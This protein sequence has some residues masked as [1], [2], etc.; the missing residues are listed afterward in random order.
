MGQLTTVRSSSHAV[1][2][3]KDTWVL[4]VDSV[5]KQ[6]PLRGYV[7]WD[8]S[9]KEI[10]FETPELAQRHDLSEGDRASIAALLQ[11]YNSD[12][13]FVLLTRS[14]SASQIKYSAQVF[15]LDYDSWRYINSEEEI[16]ADEQKKQLESARY[17][18]QVKRQ[19]RAKKRKR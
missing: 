6:L 11:D 10:F 14:E 3:V 17:V 5:R 7:F 9:D 18:R 4:I 8:T 16:K 2:A 15:P 12:T 1:Q 19:N 13:E